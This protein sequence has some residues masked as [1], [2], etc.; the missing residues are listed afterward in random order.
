MIDV[1]TEEYC[2]IYK[3]SKRGHFAKLQ[4]KTKIPFTKMAFFDDDPY[5][6]DDVKTLGVHCFLTPNGVTREI[7]NQALRSIGLS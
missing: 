4:T 7:Y 2:E 3:G 5:N 1:I 6:I